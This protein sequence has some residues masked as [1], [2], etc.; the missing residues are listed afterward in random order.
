MNRLVT[1]CSLF[2]PLLA[3]ACGD[4]DP[5]D[6]V[7]GDLAA[8]VAGDFN[9]TGILSTVSATGLD[10]D[11]GAVGGVAG[12][13]PTIRRFGN[14]LF[15]VNR[16]GGDNV[17]VLDAATLE[18][19]E[20][21]GTGDGSNPQDVAVVGNNLY[22]P[23]LGASALLVIDRGSPDDIREIDLSDLDDDDFPDCVSAYAVGSMVYVACGLLDTFSPVEDGKL[24][25]IDTSD[26]TVAHTI[27][28]PD[29]NPVGWLEQ[30]G[31][32][33]VITVQPQFN[34]TDA[35]CLARITTGATPTA[36]CGPSSEELG[37]YVA[38]AIPV[39]GQLLAAV[40]RFAEDFS[41]TSGKLVWIDL[42]GE[43]GP[44]LTPTSVIAQDLA[45]CGRN[46]F[47]ADKAADAE[48]VR[49]Y[50]LASESAAADVEETTDGALD[51]GLPPVFG[52]AIACMSI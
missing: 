47:L 51:V 17:T 44:S 12:S 18:L 34:S 38:R 8:V 28:L 35:G 41:S 39:G 33:L 10:V 13:D 9:A 7:H 14:E 19:V 43:V 22:I 30:V 21:Y 29:Q 3:A 46:V 52:N 42:D 23:A 48:G 1:T 2:L 4:D 25:V 45:V 37:G 20:Q 24:V 5:G 16:L 50:A 36:T 11:V 26:D 6:I 31:D 40:T 49:I 32:E 15:I 27:D